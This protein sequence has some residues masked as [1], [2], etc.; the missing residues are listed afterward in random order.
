[1]H[2]RAVLSGK[3]SPMSVFAGA[4][5]GHYEIVAPLGSGGMG[6]VYV[7]RDTRLDRDVAVKVLPER[8]AHD[9]DRRARFER[10]ARA[11]AA[12]SHPHILAI[13]D[14]GNHAGISYAVTELLEGQTLRRLLDGG[15]LPRRRAMDYAAQIVKAL[16]AAHTRGIVHRDLKPDN[17]FVS[18]G[19][20]IKVIDFGLAVHRPAPGGDSERTTAVLT[21]SGAVL[22]TPG[23]MSPEQVRGEAADHR[24]DIFSFGCVL[25]EMLSGRK[26]F[27]G[28]SSIDRLHATLR[29]EPCDL[30][31]LSDV[32]APLA[33]L[34][35]RCLEKNT[36]DRFQS[37]R[38]LGFALEAVGG[39]ESRSAGDHDHRAPEHTALTPGRRRMPAIALIAAISALIVAIAFGV[40]LERALGDVRSGSTAATPG[41]R[42]IAYVDHRIDVFALG[43]DSSRKNASPLLGFIGITSWFAP[44]S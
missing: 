21:D 12:L 24:S 1:M 7:A 28:E 11:V 25:Y 39:I 23:F 6:D 38:D 3:R 42:R 16:D 4:R 2:T 41:G 20:H 22:G 5:L 15:P 14:F 35:S 33:R 40:F 18:S 44:A 13:H 9:P 43:A 34:V 30:S 8:M 29:S 19:G 27:P 17:V 37:A 31:A 26:A 10:E 32:P 36:S